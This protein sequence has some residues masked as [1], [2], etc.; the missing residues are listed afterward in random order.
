MSLSFTRQLRYPSTGAFLQSERREVVVVESE[1][2]SYAR[3]SL[4]DSTHSRKRGFRRPRKPWAL[5]KEW[6]QGYAREVVYEEIK[7]IL[8]LSL[9]DAGPK[10]FVKFNPNA[11]G[12]F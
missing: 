10:V 3:D 5:V 1:S 8:E 4:F 2:D 11:A 12:K 7:A 6:L 9:E